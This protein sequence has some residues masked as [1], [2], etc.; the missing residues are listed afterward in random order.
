MP[1]RSESPRAHGRARNTSTVTFRYPS[2][3]PLVLHVH[4]RPS[5]VRA[6]IQAAMSAHKQRLMLHDID[7]GVDHQVLLANVDTWTV[8]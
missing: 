4:G 6:Q 3:R 7:T 5:E 8:K 1:R 2:G